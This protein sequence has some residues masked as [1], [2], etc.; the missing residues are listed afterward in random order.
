M[1]DAPK[2][3]VQ[4][5]AEFAAACRDEGIPAAVA[6]DV[7]ERI[8]DVAG[9]CLAGRAEETS[10]TDPGN[11]VLR[12][13][14][15]WGSGGAAEVLG[16]DVVLPA[17]NAA[18]VNGTY[19]H[20]LD[21]D[22][23]HLPSVLH[24]SAS[25]VPAAL[26]V[27]QEVGAS[28]RDLLAAVAAGIEV[29]NRLGMASYD[30]GLRNSTFFERGQHATSICGTLGAATAAALLYGL[31]A[32]GVADAVGIAASM[33]SGVLEAN[34]TGGTVKRVHCG[35]AAHGGVAAAAFAAH[36]V[37]GPPTV[38]E[39]RFG[40]FQA[41][42][43]GVYDASALLDGLGER[44]ETTRTVYKPY[45]TNHFTHPAIDC[46]IALREQG[47]DPA[48]VVAIEAGFPAPTLRTVAEPPE[49]KA[50]PRSA[51]HAKF[52]GPFTVATALLGGGGLGVYLDDF[53]DGAHQDPARLDLAAKVTCFADERASEIF[54]NAF[55]AVV[56][57][58]TRG[59]SVLEHRVD[60]SRG[61]PGHPL[62]AAD[63]RAKFLLNAARAVGEPAAEA[64]AAAVTGL[65]DAP[66]VGPLTSGD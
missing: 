25:V 59:G 41:W 16:T 44:W 34:R 37:T 56:R 10:E 54:P 52:S 65:G 11:A 66:R 62:P 30:K 28:G 58:T 21:F 43:S 32:G 64:L 2:T 22:D 42:L 48:D 15:T 46:A 47:L 61:G 53:A 8:L 20:A 39:G 9:N 29:C 50:R 13:V 51:Y 12:T 4:A 57:V 17:P 26:A 45:P 23:T 49:D 36:G 19:A 63:L 18:L 33:G 5:L 60:S 1:S 55:A 7:S 27:A 3:Q 40:F 14:S 6:K 24:P 31:D 38:I 35:W